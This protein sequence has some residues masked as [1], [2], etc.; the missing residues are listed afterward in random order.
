MKKRKLRKHIT[1]P[2]SASELLRQMRITKKELEDAIR[3]IT[4]SGCRRKKR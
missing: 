2:L 4:D 3:A 1:F